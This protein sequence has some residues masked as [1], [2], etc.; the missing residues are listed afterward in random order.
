MLKKEDKK[1]LGELLDE[2]FE[3]LK[4]ESPDMERLKKIR[5]E[6]LDIRKKMDDVDKET[7]VETK[8]CS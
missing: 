4:S 6:L 3:I 2:T 8:V 7:K 1:R 5:D